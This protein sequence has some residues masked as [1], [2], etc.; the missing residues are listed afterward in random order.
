MT[1][2]L[3]GGSVSLK[4]SRKATWHAH[5]QKNFLKIPK[6]VKNLA[7]FA[8]ELFILLNF[9][10]PCYL[11]TEVVSEWYL[12][13]ISVHFSPH[14]VVLTCDRHFVTQAHRRAISPNIS[15]VILCIKD[16]LVK[17]SMYCS[18]FLWSAQP[19]PRTLHPQNSIQLPVCDS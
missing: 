7:E 8:I 15:K 1:R 16:S 18:T 6:T 4:S 13:P 11:V 10:L 19:T 17:A 12:W 14:T 9:T 3:L 5:T 2:S